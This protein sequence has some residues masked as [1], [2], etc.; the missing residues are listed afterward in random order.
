VVGV[1]LLGLRGR[2]SRAEKQMLKSGVEGKFRV[3]G[4]GWA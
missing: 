2:R 1:E 3:F 4:R